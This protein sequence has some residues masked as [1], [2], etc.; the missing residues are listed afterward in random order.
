VR[1]SEGKSIHYEIDEIEQEAEA[2][3]D[4][5]LNEHDL[6]TSLLENNHLDN[7]LL[8]DEGDDLMNMH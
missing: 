7:Y 6:E 4:N 3:F 5:M 2:F 1:E 8:E